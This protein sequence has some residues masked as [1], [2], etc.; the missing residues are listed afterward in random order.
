MLPGGAVLRFPGAYL[1]PRPFP[2][3]LMPQLPD[4]RSFFPVSPTT[5]VNLHEVASASLTSILLTSGRRVAI[6]PAYQEAVRAR[7]AAAGIPTVAG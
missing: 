1:Y 4:H 7:L 2:L 6:D 3:L 5:L